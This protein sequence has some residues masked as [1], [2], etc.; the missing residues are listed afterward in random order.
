[1]IKH[2]WSVVCTEVLTAQETNSVSYI[3]CIERIQTSELPCVL[4]PFWLTT[5]WT[6][7]APESELL[8]VKVL[9]VDPDGKKRAVFESE[10]VTVDK[11]NVRV[12][13][14]VVGLTVGSEGTHNLR[15]Q[16]RRENR[17]RRVADLPLHVA[18]SGKSQPAQ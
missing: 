16:Q 14:R 17:W 6:R 2:V 7:Q 15:V 18:F 3:N 5:L 8:R 10:E 9:L 12:N 4:P 11:Q 13:I 1:M